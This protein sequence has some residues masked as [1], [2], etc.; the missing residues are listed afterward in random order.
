MHAAL[1][2]GLLATAGA[3]REHFP[4]NLFW[5][6]DG[7]IGVTAREARDPLE[8]RAAFDDIVALHALFGGATAIRFRYV[9]DFVYGFDWARWVAGDPAS[10]AHVHPFS[11]RF[12]GVMLGRGDKL[13]RQIAD[14]DAKYPQLR[15]SKHRNPFGFSRDPED[16]VRLYRD[17]AERGLIP[18]QAWEDDA[19]ARWDRPYT[20]ARDE[21][22]AAL[23]LTPASPSK[24]PPPTPAAG[25]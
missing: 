22:A 7:L 25:A 21:R 13:L 1:T 9:H 18:V 14:D 15:D 5:D 6:L 24:G 3:I 4:E 10:R 16:E 23:G 11:R 12:V 17:L 19:P 2:E 20:R 8:L